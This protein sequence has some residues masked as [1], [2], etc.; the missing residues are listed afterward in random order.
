MNV[1]LKDEVEIVARH[2]DERWIVDVTV[3]KVQPRSTAWVKGFLYIGR[4]ETGDIVL[5]G[6]VSADNL[7]KPQPVSLTVHVSTQAKSID[8]K[9]LLRVEHER[10][11]ASPEGQRW[12]E[13]LERRVREKKS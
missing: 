4:R 12:Q 5:A 8:L 13:R 2:V 9:E 3:E 1:L 6:T 10:Y 11:L 7:P